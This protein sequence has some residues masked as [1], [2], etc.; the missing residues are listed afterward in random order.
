MLHSHL[1]L[2]NSSL[3]TMSKLTIMGWIQPKLLVG[4]LADMSIS[5]S[6]NFIVCS[7]IFFSKIK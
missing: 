1:A 6:Y 7:A 4:Q 5:I 3:S 2:G